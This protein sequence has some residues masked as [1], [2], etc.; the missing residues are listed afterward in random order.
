VKHLLAI[1]AM[2]SFLCSARALGGTMSTRVETDYDIE[3]NHVTSY[4]SFEYYRST[5]E[6]TDYRYFTLQYLQPWDYWTDETG[7]DSWSHTETVWAETGECYYTDLAVQRFDAAT[8]ALLEN[9]AD[10]SSTVCV[11]ERCLFIVWEFWGADIHLDQAGYF[12]VG[13][14][15][16]FTALDYPDLTFVGWGGNVTTADRTVSG[17]L[18]STSFTLEAIYNAREPAS[19]NLQ[20]SINVDGS[21]TSLRT[22]RWPAGATISY[23]PI[24]PLEYRFIGWSGVVNSSQET[25][26]FQMPGQDTGLC[27]NFTYV[28][29][30]SGD[31]YSDPENEDLSC[32]P[33][34]DV[35]CHSSPVIINLEK[36][37]YRL[38]G[39]NAPVL[40]DMAG[41]GQP[42]PMGWTAA[43]TDEAFLWLDR[44]HNGKV[45]SGAE[46]FGNFTPLENGH[47]AKNG[48]EALRELDANGDGV[49][50]ERDPI[51][52]RLMLWRDLN[53]DGIS[54]QNEIQPI[55][56]SDVTSI[57]LHDHWTGR[58][59]TSGNQF[60]YEAL[61]SIKD[62]S[63]HGVHKQP[64]YDI[65]F[66]PLPYVP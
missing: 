45:T 60:R 23:S 35:N 14:H 10:R 50:D 7:L 21:V 11:P 55:T 1:L 9:S 3:S 20:I 58:H 40:F 66:V 19:Y 47:L 24:T 31:T 18:D 8:G 61:V 48:F 49:I 12:P 34:I 43:G 33:G 5:F 59:D 57:D 17:T 62:G 54:E 6:A 41:T 37:D 53:H 52:P 32:F 44:N 36:G 29:S 25:V 27:A 16:S 22:D 63:G 26:T 2:M 13:S 15:Y 56:Q 46:L 30:G 42:R 39:R 28:G 38:T 64:V 51:W 4:A 65:F